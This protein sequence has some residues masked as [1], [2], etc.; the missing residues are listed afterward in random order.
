MAFQC[1]QACLSFGAEHWKFQTHLSSIILVQ[2]QDLCRTVQHQLLDGAGDRGAADT[3]LGTCNGERSSRVVVGWVRCAPGGR[4]TAL[5]DDRDVLK[6][7]STKVPVNIVP[8]ILMST[9]IASQYI[10]IPR[11]IDSQLNG[12]NSLVETLARKRKGI[13]IRGA[14]GSMHNG[15]LPVGTVHAH[16]A[17]RVGLARIRVEAGSPCQRRV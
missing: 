3:G 5:G 16:V 7:K 12:K 15:R 6:G 17:K 13:H 2:E 10:H 4:S 9:Q 14:G 11:T 8:I 1:L